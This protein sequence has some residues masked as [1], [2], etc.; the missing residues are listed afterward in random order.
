M[1][2]IEVFAEVLGAL[3]TYAA[4][5]PGVACA[6]SLLQS[7]LD[8]GSGLASGGTVSARSQPSPGPSSSARE[9]RHR[10]DPLVAD[11]EPWGL[12]P[13]YGEDR[14]VLLPRDPTAL[15]AFWEVTPATRLRVLRQL[16]TTAEGARQVLRLSHATPWS[17]GGGAVLLEIEVPPAVQRW[18]LVVPRPGGS[19]RVEL[20][21]RLRNGSFVPLIPSAATDLPSTTPPPEGFLRWVAWNPH[22]PAREVRRAWAGTPLPVPAA[23]TSTSAPGSPASSPARW[24]S[25]P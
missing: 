5:L 9:R 24:F 21:L 7:L 13:A 23:E 14:L 18:H 20:G 12:P 8:T 16:G 19:Y 10:A 17:A 3:R 1:V 2:V 15:F 11:R 25:R 6:A 4:R 22:G